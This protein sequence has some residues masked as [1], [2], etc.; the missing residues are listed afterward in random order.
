MIFCLKVDL[1]REIHA[2]SCSSKPLAAWTARDAIQECREACGGHGYSAGNTS[3]SIIG[4]KTSKALAFIL[5]SF[6]Q[7]SNFSQTSFVFAL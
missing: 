3:Y 7:T 2:L 5:L 6:V 1:G 4:L